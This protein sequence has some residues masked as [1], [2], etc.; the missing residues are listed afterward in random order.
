M[1]SRLVQVLCDG[2]IQRG[3]DAVKAI[4]VGASA[5]CIGRPA[6]YGL[7]VVGEEGVAEVNLSVNVVFSRRSFNYQSSSFLLSTRIS[8]SDLHTLRFTLSQVLS[9]L[10]DDID[11]TLGLVGV[12]DIADVSR[13]RVVV[14]RPPPAAPCH[15]SG[16]VAYTYNQSLR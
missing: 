2:G 5:V 13:A 12:D 11:R 16:A 8:S 10:V 7:A 4:S 15:E 1:L 14:S 6:L 9:I 3:S